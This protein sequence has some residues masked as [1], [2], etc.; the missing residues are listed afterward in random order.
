MI[1]LSGLLDISTQI[2]FLNSSVIRKCSQY[3]LDFPRSLT[4][5]YTR[6]TDGRQA[7]QIPGT[8]AARGLFR[9]RECTLPL[10]RSQQHTMLL[11]CQVAL[12]RGAD[13]ASDY[14]G[15][16][17]CF[18][19]RQ[20][21]SIHHQ[22]KIGFYSV[23]LYWLLKRPWETKGGRTVKSQ[24]PLTVS[25]LHIC[26]TETCIRNLLSGMYHKCPSSPGGGSLSF[27]TVPTINEHEP[28]CDTSITALN[29]N[30]NLA[31]LFNF[32]LMHVL[33]LPLNCEVR[34]GHHV[35]HVLSQHSAS[36]SL[37]EVLNGY[38]RIR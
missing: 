1:L 3:S 17:W 11:I 37:W 21:N 15:E 34:G 25:S 18:H 29:W 10:L 35:S 26:P 33:S 30:L 32:S 6:V 9:Y 8:S 27:W 12:T 28:P 31:L 7:P 22:W 23:G 5:K 24:A 4:Q 36:L 14:P 13:T 16:S 19:I 20:V 2:L 38:W